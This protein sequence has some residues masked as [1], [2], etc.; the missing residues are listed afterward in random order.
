[1]M[2]PIFR[3]SLSSLNF[4]R[5]MR[6]SM[7]VRIAVPISMTRFALLSESSISRHGPLVY[8]GELDSYTRTIPFPVIL[9]QESRHAFNVTPYHQRVLSFAVHHCVECA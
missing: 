8:A 9:A 7:A 3:I 1:M 2:K 4:P 5:S 6:W